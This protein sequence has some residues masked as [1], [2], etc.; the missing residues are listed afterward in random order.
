VP[1][2]GNNGVLIWFP[3]DNAGKRDAVQQLVVILVLVVLGSL[4]SA[5]PLRY[6]PATQL[7]AVGPNFPVPIQFPALFIVLTGV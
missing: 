7:F 1:T 6:Y 2:L 4:A 3:T 5:F